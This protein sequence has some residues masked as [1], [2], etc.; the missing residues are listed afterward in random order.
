MKRQLAAYAGTMIVMVGLDMLWLGVIAK[1][2]YQNGIGHLMADQPN[3]SVAVLFYALYGLGLV[4]FAVLP[5]GPAPG[6]AKTVGMAALFGFF[7]Y[8]TY[9]LTN[10]ATLKQWPI[11]LSVMDM[12]WGTC[13]SAAAAAGGK[14]LMDWM[15]PT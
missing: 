7:A 5:A 15:A 10:L 13:I 3:V 1:P 6:W 4:V 9:D 8:A 12:A 11:G 14:A 2:I